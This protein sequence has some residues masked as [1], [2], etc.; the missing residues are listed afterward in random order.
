EAEKIAQG[1]S[2]MAQTRVDRIVDNA[3]RTVGP[4]HEQINVID[5]EISLLAMELDPPAAQAEEPIAEP[6]TEIDLVALQESS[7]LDMNM[8][9]TETSGEES[10][11]GLQDLA[12]EAVEAEMV[13]DV[14]GYAD[15][16]LPKREYSLREPQ[17][18][19][20]QE[21]VMPLQGDAMG[22]FEDLPLPR[23]GYSL[24]EPDNAPNQVEQEQ[25][26]EEVF[27]DDI[28]PMLLDKWEYSLRE[29]GDVEIEVEEIT[30]ESTEADLPYAHQEH[31]GY[32]MGVAEVYEKELQA[33]DI[34]VLGADETEM[35]F[36]V[37]IDSRHFETVDGVKTPIH[38][39]NWQVKVDVE[40]MEKNPDAPGYA[41]ISSIVDC[42]L[43]R[44]DG[45]L[46]NEA[47]PFTIIE[48]SCNNMAMY[49]FNFLDDNLVL[50][51]M[52]VKGVTLWENPDDAVTVTTRNIE[53]D[54]L[55]KRGEE[56]IF[57]GLRDKINN[58]NSS[59]SVNTSLKD[60]LGS[61][62]KGR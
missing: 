31:H 13:D 23:R 49:F 40:T 43:L 53:I 26:G 50:L 35:R 6:K 33:L 20:L 36:D 56:D 3:H 29:P 27:N 24:R 51:G 10:S 11:L 61:I 18:E 54:A 9:R 46:L 25:K 44:Y 7:A 8:D 52:A 60:R 21:P 57:G 30:A 48:P 22:S 45:V 16:P 1:I 34:E 62:F 58:N 39:H 4:L 59:I 42:T 47:Y 12:A 38:R 28:P 41:K 5:K 19:S 55:L 17:D 2:D 15:M 32:S 37:F 14:A